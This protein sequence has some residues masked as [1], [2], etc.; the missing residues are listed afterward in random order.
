[1]SVTRTELLT[2]ATNKA[3]EWSK[4]Y[5]KAKRL[6]RENSSI[7]L[8]QLYKIRTIEDAASELNIDLTDF[9]INSMN[10]ILTNIN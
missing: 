9:Q 7:L 6:Q 4:K 3:I 10:S 5:Q 8:C 2:A 1:M